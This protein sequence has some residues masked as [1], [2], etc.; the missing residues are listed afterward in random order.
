MTIAPEMATFSEPKLALFPSRD[1]SIP[2]KLQSE[3]QTRP[4]SKSPD[5]E[6]APNTVKNSLSKRKTLGI[7]S[8]GTS[9][10]RKK[11]RKAE[12]GS[13][14][15]LKTILSKNTREI[16]FKPLGKRPEYCS[17]CNEILEDG[18]LI[19]EIK[20]CKHRSHVFCLQRHILD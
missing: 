6:T 10:K 8:I 3:T 9:E 20:W 4:G 5:I 15:F 12:I 13:D 17:V 16:S 11:K 14:V 18:V 19:R 1:S 7:E 2:H